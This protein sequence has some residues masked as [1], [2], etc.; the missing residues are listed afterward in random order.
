MTNIFSSSKP[1]RSIYVDTTFCIPKAF[2]IP[3]RKQCE[4]GVI[5]LVNS[6]FQEYGP[7]GHVWI[8]SRTKYGHETLLK[9]LSIHMKMKVSFKI[10]SSKKKMFSVDKFSY[11]LFLLRFTNR[12]FKLIPQYF[13]LDHIFK[14][15]FSA[16]FDSTLSLHFFNSLYLINISPFIEFC[17]HILKRLYCIGNMYLVFKLPT[18]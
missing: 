14:M 16:V 1:L 3:S 6:H 11:L 7:N 2:Y 10:S 4:D 15:Y 8:E 5:S 9:E 17:S 12:L 13:F 18:I